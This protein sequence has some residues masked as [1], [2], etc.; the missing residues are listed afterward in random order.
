MASASP[1]AEISFDWRAGHSGE[2][3]ELINR[4][5]TTFAPQLKA[6]LQSPKFRGK[7]MDKDGKLN[8]NAIIKAAMKM[9][10]KNGLGLRGPQKLSLVKSL[11]HGLIDD[12]DAI[13]STEKD[14]LKSLTDTGINMTVD[15]LLTK[16]QT[17][18][19]KRGCAC[20]F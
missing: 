2:E 15:Y 14:L 4:A 9:A 17:F 3:V 6:K 19:E 16:I 18:A 10:E 11:L 13:G 8:Y 1:A 12:D 20:P 5:R 7:Y